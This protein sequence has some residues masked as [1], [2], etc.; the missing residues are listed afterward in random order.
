MSQN[1]H[2]AMP[3]D[4]SSRWRD[5]TAIGSSIALHVCALAVLLAVP[6]TPPLPSEEPDE[7]ALLTSIVRLERPTPPPRRVAARTAKPVEHRIAPAAP[8]PPLRVAVA[9]ERARRPL[10]VAP[11]HRYVPPAPHAHAPV[12]RAQVAAA[13]G[14]L[15]QAPVADAPRTTVTA[16]PTPTPVVV[17][18]A[19]PATVEQEMSQ[20]NFGES[21]PARPMPGMV[22][23]LRA[24]TPHL[25]AH[26][27]VDEHGHA[28]SVVVVA[29]V[30]DAAQRD[31]ITR[32]LLA[33]TYIP[34]SCNGLSCTQ[35]FDLR[36]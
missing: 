34:A 10:V 33:A 35:T 4:A 28:T 27:T 32:A 3:T 7:R 36:V 5:R 24:K 2:L 17:A 31:E 14:N 21:Y 30:D 8:P 23:A 22:D 19:T 25:I 29:G 6:R 15:D 26:V 13:A 12:P 1:S 11:E 20:G 16:T 18:A 9:K